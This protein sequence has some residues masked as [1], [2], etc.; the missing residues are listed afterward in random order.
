[1]RLLIVIVNYQTPELAIDCLRSLVGE[2]D[3][4]ARVVVTDNLSADSSAEKISSAIDQNGWREW[5]S[6]KALDRNAG[7]AAGNNAAI[8]PAL[9]SSD[10]PQ[11]VLLLNPDTMVRPGAVRELVSFMDVNPRVGIAGSRLEDP[12]GAPQRSAFRFPGLASEFERGV[13]LGIVSKLLASRIVAPPAPQ[14]AC[15]TD[16]IAGA[17]MIIRRDVFTGVG[18]MDEKYF[19][20]FE[21]VDFCLAA[22]RAG[23]QCWYVP[24]SRVVHLVGAATQLSDQR[25]HRQRRPKY[26]FDARRRYFVKNHGV[27]YAGLADIAFAVGFALWRVRR[28]IQRKEDPDPPKLLS[29][30][31]RNSV[32][33]RG[34]AV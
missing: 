21:E 16:W 18:L 26:W 1:M 24:T 20:Y 31:I 8:A 10:P 27:I 19:M 32:F 28:A 11:Y 9:K 30:F 14:A 4:D 34:A 33:V 15:S 3:S 12:D 23:W 29:D 22:K 13:R 5:A 2:L 25:K 7:F 17:S 6:L